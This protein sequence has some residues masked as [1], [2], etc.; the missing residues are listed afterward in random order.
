MPVHFAAEGKSERNTCKLEGVSKG[1]DEILLIRIDHQRWFIHK[2]NEAGRPRTDLSDVVDAQAL[3][4]E[5]RGMVST[6][7]LFQEPV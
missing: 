4:F 5:H 2:H 7:R 3:A 1:I 6:D